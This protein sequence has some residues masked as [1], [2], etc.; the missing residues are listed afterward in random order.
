MRIDTWISGCKVYGFPWIDGKTFYLNVQYFA[1]GSSINK[2]VW[3]RSVLIMQNE[4]GKQ[5]LRE[6]LHTLV[7]K[8][9]MSDLLN[10]ADRKGKLPIWEFK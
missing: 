2:P 10:D 9:C 4:K 1:S 6:H 5:I 7:N 8:I 3:G